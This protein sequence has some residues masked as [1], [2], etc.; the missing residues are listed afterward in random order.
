MTEYLDDG[1]SAVISP[2]AELAVYVSPNGDHVCAVLAPSADVIPP[3][4]LGPRHG[5][6]LIVVYSAD[7]ATLLS[8]YMVSAKVAA[9][10][11]AS[12][13]WLR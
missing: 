10:I 6:W 12:A 1:H 4:R 9:P 11:P 7:S 2:R 8:I 13:I 5:A 3:V